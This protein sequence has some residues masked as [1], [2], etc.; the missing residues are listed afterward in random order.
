MGPLRAP[1]SAPRGGVEPVV[2]AV[3]EAVVDVSPS[4][5]VDGVVVVVVDAVGVTVRV[6]GGRPWDAMVARCG[7]WRIDPPTSAC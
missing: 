3:V 5:V 4:V 7:G 2:D 6:A 1:S